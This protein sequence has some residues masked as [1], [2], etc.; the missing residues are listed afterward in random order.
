MN[1]RPDG[2]AEH[3]DPADDDTVVRPSAGYHAEPGAGRGLDEDTVVRAPRTDAGS[4]SV[5]PTDDPTLERPAPITDGAGDPDGDLEPTVLRRRVDLDQTLVLDESAFAPD[6][7]TLRRPASAPTPAPAPEPGDGFIDQVPLGDPGSGAQASPP[8]MEFLHPKEPTEA[9]PAEQ[10]TPST[11]AERMPDTAP[12]QRFDVRPRFEVPQTPPVLPPQEDLPT[13]DTPPS[14]S[15]PP[16]P[17]ALSPGA[18]GAATGAVGGAGYAGAGPS[19]VGPQYSPAGPPSAAGQ[20]SPVSSGPTPASPAPSA[21]SPSAPSPAWP[22]GV[23]ATGGRR[24]PRFLVPALAAGCVLLLVLMIGGGLTAVYLRGGELG[25]PVATQAPSQGP[26]ETEPGVWAP[27]GEGTVPGGDAA[28]LRQ[29]LIENPL[30]SA[31]LPVPAQCQLPEADAGLVPADDLPTYL[32][33]G[34]ACLATT[35][36]DALATQDVTLPNLSV[37][38]FTADAPPANSA[39][40]AD[41]FTG[42]APVACTDDETVYWPATWDPGFSNASAEEVPQLYMW[43]LSYST[44]I[45]VMNAL[46]L[47]GYY[48]ALLVALGD[49]QAG[50]EEAQRRYNLQLSCMASAA[51]FQLPQ[52]V[53]P[54]G[55][56]EQFVTSDAAQAE[57][58]SA[59]DPSRQSRA[60]WVGAG[61]DARGFLSECATW[62]ADAEQVS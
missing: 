4:T 26:A 11:P 57:P 33:A 47:D 42:D 46:S 1:T 2:A 12:I 44:A 7:E 27:L 8:A 38:V 51:A 52:G 29:V 59:G 39:C 35:W 16:R 3:E 53:R 30:V 14:A 20:H 10:G 48:A 15:A 55:R 62:S 37:E 22:P 5:A 50:A 34:M 61:R 17:A 41:R 43:H 9:A 32:E 60:A 40:P 56:V 24:R 28:D 45:L 25:E 31:R 6:E 58:A 54:T 23:D 21:A 13:D 36:R 19:P 49:D 18:A